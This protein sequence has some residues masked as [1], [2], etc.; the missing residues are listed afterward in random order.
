MEEILIQF[1]IQ[2]A[3]GY[4]IVMTIFIVLGVLRAVNKPLFT[5]WRS[6]VSATP[7]KSDDELLDTVE[8]SKIVKALLFVLDW[9]AS[10][11]VPPKTEEK[12]A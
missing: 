5:L 6:Y 3:Q 4:P 9:T 12:K 10:I 7:Q 11:K 1:L 2:A 8:R